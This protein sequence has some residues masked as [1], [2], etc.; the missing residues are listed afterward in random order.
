MKVRKV[1]LEIIDVGLSQNESRG[2]AGLCP[3]VVIFTLYN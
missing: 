2:L 3:H 1:M